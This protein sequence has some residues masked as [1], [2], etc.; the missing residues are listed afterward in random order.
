MDPIE[1]AVISAVLGSQFMVVYRLG[2]VEQKLK[3]LYRI[4]NNNNPGGK[5]C[6]KKRKS[7]NLE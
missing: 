6:Q 4:I 7:T 5:P 1:L 2:K 3:D